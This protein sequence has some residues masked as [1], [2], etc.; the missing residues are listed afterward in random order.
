M[1]I[2]V[3][4]NQQFLT[5]LFAGPFRGH[6]IIMDAPLPPREP[7]EALDD[8]DFAISQ[9]PVKAWVPT[10]LRQYE[11]MLAWHEALGDDGVPFARLW[12]GTEIIAAAFGCPVHVYEDSPPCALPLVTTAAEADAITLPD[13]HARPLERV[14]E[15]GTLLR[16]RL[17]PDV[18][19]GVPDIQSPFDIAALIWRKEDFFIALHEE[20]EAVKRLVAKC[21]QLLTTFL[22]EFKRQFPNCN[23]CHCPNAWAPPELGCWLSE[24]EAGSLSVPMFEEFCQPVLGDLSRTFGGLFMHCCATADHQYA[25]FK[26]IPNL[27]GLNRYFQEPGPGPAIR[28]F[29]GHCVLMMAWFDEATLNMMLDLA[30]PDSRFLLN[31]SAATLDEAKALYERLRI[32]CPRS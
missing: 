17:G 28:T 10:I 1:T 20:P 15:L 29:A 23:L 32:R 14:F 3:E 25:E 27:R 4:R 12:T 22:H 19:L 5:D 21:Q 31:P 18:P 26:K 6:A 8:G 13:L 9:R 2:D 11:N 7:A 24:D 16:D 30:L